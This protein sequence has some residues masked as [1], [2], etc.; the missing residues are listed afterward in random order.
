MCEA[1]LDLVPGSAMADGGVEP[2][3]HVI[4]LVSLDQLEEEKEKGE[5]NCL[6]LLG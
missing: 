3:L 5:R 4:V 1:T 6:R 2:T